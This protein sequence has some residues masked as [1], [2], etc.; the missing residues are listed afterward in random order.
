MTILNYKDRDDFLKNHVVIPVK[1]VIFF[2]SFFSF[3]FIL[4]IS[5]FQYMTYTQL[6]CIILKH[7]ELQENFLRL[8][9]ENATL[10]IQ[11]SELTAQ[12]PVLISA[13]KTVIE[14]DYFTQ[15]IQSILF[16]K[17]FLYS[18]GVVVVGGGVSVCLSLV[19]FPIF[20]AIGNAI[21]HVKTLPILGF[22]FN[23]KPIDFSIK[24][25]DQKLIDILNLETLYGSIVLKSNNTLA[26]V[27][28]GFEKITLQ[29]YDTFFTDFYSR[30]VKS[31]AEST[32]RT[33][34]LSDITVITKSS[35]T[36]PSVASKLNLKNLEEACDYI[37]SQIISNPIL[38][39]AFSAFKDL[40]AQN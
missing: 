16:S 37:Q 23:Q 29:E 36:V 6:D 4:S 2:L 12:M 31:V 25:S 24:L 14:V 39:D 8:A 30:I 38:M 33:S 26:Y 15:W 20:A 19:G 21:M 35:E 27:K 22:I 28:L 13:Q 10:K 9:A 32:F 7:A 5:F 11:V 34:S 18:A 17:I 40:L 3:F 1:N